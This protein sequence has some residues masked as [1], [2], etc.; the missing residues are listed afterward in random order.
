MITNQKQ[1]KITKAHLEEFE[2]ALAERAA[3]PIPEGVDEGMWQLEQ[4]ALQS[5]IEDFKADLSAFERL[6][7]GDIAETPLNSLADLPVLLIQARIAQGLTQK[8][9]AEKLNVKEQQVQKDEASLYE[10]ASLHRLLR[11][12]DALGLEFHGQARLPVRS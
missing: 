6:Q 2:A 3:M 8:A 12:A 5:Q 11:I 1:Y 9:F 10:S 7:A 4:D